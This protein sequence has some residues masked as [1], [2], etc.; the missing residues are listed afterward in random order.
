VDVAIAVV[1]GQQPSWW[2]AVEL[3]TAVLWMVVGVV[4]TLIHPVRRIGVM[5]QLLGLVLLV[6][7]PAGFDLVVPPDL[8]GWIAADLVLARAVLPFQVVVFAHLL[9][10]YP[11]GPVHR[12]F[13]RGF[14]IA[15]YGY[16][17]LV[18]VIGAIGVVGE[19]TRPGWAGGPPEAG[20][21]GSG[22]LVVLDVGWLAFAAV[23]VVLLWLRIRSVTPTRR[24]TLAYPL[25]CG[26]VLIVGFALQ[27]LLT[28]SGVLPVTNRLA[29]V[30]PYLAI[31]TLPGA[32][33]LGLVRERVRYGLA[34][35]LVRELA[36]TPAGGME[37][38]LRRV[39]NDPTLR[40]V[41]VDSVEVADDDAVGVLRIGDALLLHDPALRDEP[42]LLEAAAAAIR[43]ALDNARLSA[44]AHVTGQRVIAAVDDERRRLER[45][46]HDGPQQRML[47][48]GIALRLL[49]QRL[50]LRDAAIATAVAEVHQ[51]LTGA[52]RELRDLARGIY[53]AVLIDEGIS[54]AVRTLVRRQPFTVDLDDALPERLPTSVEK[55][56]Y[57]VVA[58]ALSNVAKHARADAV[59]VRL[60]VVE[61]RLHVE[62]TDDG[63]GGAVLDRGSGL[64]GLAER[65]AALDG[66]LSV[67]DRSPRGT[68]LHVELPC[69]W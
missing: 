8:A 51:E 26:I 69:A 27:T 41:F 16:A 50:D 49:E 43:L 31:V 30:L 62:V 11:D 25:G 57:F 47:A 21:A 12:G 19:V 53:P 32:F 14:V 38:A 35:D 40:L 9:L 15:A 5:M 22:S 56:A 20:F 68:R 64:R 66:S 18:G 48:A 13:Q 3:G 24:R 60:S 2:Y 67:G 55:A 7:A 46:L 37:D 65:A 6:D 10:T 59:R 42:R 4:A 1:A 63:V 61:D 29:D 45:D 28:A 52:I 33:L 34:A 44:E 36:G 39:L 58:E 17:G 54:A 23:Y